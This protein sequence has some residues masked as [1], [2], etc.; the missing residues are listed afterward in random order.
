M[1]ERLDET[2]EVACR[3]CGGE[4]I[5]RDLGVT[6]QI[7]GGQLTGQDHGGFWECLNKKCGY[8]EEG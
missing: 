4:M 7:V 3:K 6:P 1:I 2:R 5:Y 8:T